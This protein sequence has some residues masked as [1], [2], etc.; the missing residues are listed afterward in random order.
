MLKHS[1]CSWC[2]DP[3]PLE[4]QAEWALALGYAG[5]DLLTPAQAESL[6]SLGLACPVTAAPEHESG[7][8]C[9]EKAF[10]R[11]E[12]HA[13]LFEIYERLI[14]EAAAAGIPHVITF[15]GNREGLDDE[16]GLENCARGLEPLLPLAEKHGVTLIMELL[17]SNIDHPDYQCD[18][19]DWGVA[20]CEKIDAPQFK[21]LYDIY[22]MQ[23]ME[24]DLINTIRRHHR[25]IA[26]YHTA[27]SPGRNEINDAQEL[28]YPAIV[29]AIR[30]T[31]YRGFLA[32]EF[33]PLGDPVSG[34]R[35]AIA[36]C[37]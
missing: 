3:A 6:K 32:Q 12:H 34:L 27:G 4:Q 8:G 2:Y 9:I 19:T 10:N 20:L 35:D 26:H 7:L 36:R 5:I 23:V 14:P 1:F 24:G 37:S 29:R 16:S 28:H 25:H 15:S 18:R 33:V 17:N 30:E 22:H 11:P 13:T 31:G 21:L